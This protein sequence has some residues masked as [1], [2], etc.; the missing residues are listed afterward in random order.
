MDD[1][2]AQDIFPETL[3]LMAGKSIFRWHSFGCQ[4]YFFSAKALPR[5]SPFTPF[6]SKSTFWTNVRGR[7]AAERM[8]Q[9]NFAKC[10][11]YKYL[12]FLF[13]FKR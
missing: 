9:E 8:R 7:K 4:H 2:W 3:G 5:V 1:A 10:L 12:L 13:L 6:K 11:S